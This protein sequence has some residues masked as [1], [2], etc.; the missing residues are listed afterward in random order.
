MTLISTYWTNWLVI[1]V[2]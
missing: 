1:N 2:F